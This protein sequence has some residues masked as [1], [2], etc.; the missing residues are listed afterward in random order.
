MYS[1]KAVLIQEAQYFQDIVAYWIQYQNITS[2]LFYFYNKV[3]VISVSIFMLNK[4]RI[5]RR[6]ILY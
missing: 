3:C 1:G 6:E 2:N 5:K 4:E